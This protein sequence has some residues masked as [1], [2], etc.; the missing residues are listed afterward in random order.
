MIAKFDKVLYLEDVLFLVCWHNDEVPGM[1]MH[2]L[3][4][5]S[6]NHM[7]YFHAMIKR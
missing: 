7:L 4:L 2:E 6:A 3:L 1:I 5:H